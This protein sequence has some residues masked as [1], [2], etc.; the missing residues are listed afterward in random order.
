MMSSSAFALDLA[1]QAVTHRSGARALAARTIIDIGSYKISGMVGTPLK[2]G[3]FSIAACETIASDGIFRGDV[4]DPEAASHALSM[5]IERLENAADLPIDRATVVT[6]VG[7][8]CA[9]HC[10]E[11]VKLSR[12]TV[13]PEALS[14]AERQIRAKVDKSPCFAL[15]IVPVSFEVDGQR[16]S[17]EPV[18]IVGDVLKVRFLV[19]YAERRAV[20]QLRR[21][22]RN[23]H[24]T[25]ERFVAGGVASAYA[26]LSTHEADQG[27]IVLEV[28]GG[29]SSISVFRNETLQFLYTLPLGGQDMSRDLACLLNTSFDEAER[30]KTLHGGVNPRLC[31][32]QRGLIV[33]TLNE[34]GEA[35]Q[36]EV[37]KNY[38]T[39]ILGSR[40]REITEKLK[41]I[42]AN[43]A[44]VP[45]YASEMSFVVTGGSSQLEGVSDALEECFGVTPRSGG[46]VNLTGQYPEKFLQPCFAGMAGGAAVSFMPVGGRWGCS[47]DHGNYSLGHA[48]GKMSRW[49]KENF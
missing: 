23:C 49:F 14:L 42:L 9:D 7:Q 38:S 29:L 40:F 13:T 43:N 20:E 1:S 25:A 48:V 17:R 26:S 33:N 6:N 21:V 16:Y 12:N 32:E 15:H 31:D 2:S 35:D 41:E 3:D 24:V 34:F 45:E 5:L 18:G 39:A 10:Y 28:G 30:L 37:T 46:I 36:A 22:M 27:A 8:P 11:T 19:V 4:H 47:P 44:I